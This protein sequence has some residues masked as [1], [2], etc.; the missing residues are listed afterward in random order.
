MESGLSNISLNGKLF[1]ENKK[2]VT[3]HPGATFKGEDGNYFLFDV[4]PGKW[5]FVLY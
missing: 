3:K 2:S 1:V 5:S 4:K